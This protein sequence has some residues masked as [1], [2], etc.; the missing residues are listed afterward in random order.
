MNLNKI[1][2]IFLSVFTLVLQR[3][4]HALETEGWG[5][6][7]LNFEEVNCISSIVSSENSFLESKW[8]KLWWLSQI[9]TVSHF[10][11]SQACKGSLA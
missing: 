3:V 4:L 10:L 6:T 7:V 5:A 9:L 11:G 8:L 1:S 2:A